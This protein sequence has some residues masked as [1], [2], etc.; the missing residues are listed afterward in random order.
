[1]LLGVCFV[2]ENDDVFAEE[3]KL[4]VNVLHKMED[5]S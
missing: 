4:V 5:I 1:M 3:K 2:E